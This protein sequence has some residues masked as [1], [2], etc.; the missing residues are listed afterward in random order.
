MSAKRTDWKIKGFEHLHN[1]SVVD[2]FRGI[3][4]RADAA[5]ALFGDDFQLVQRSRKYRYVY[6]VGSRKEVKDMRAA[7]RYPV[8]P[9]PKNA[10]V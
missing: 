4:N 7:L 3:E 9:Y 6:F 2:M 1:Q 10:D 8:L 5:R